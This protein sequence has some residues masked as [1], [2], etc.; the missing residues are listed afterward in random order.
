M[1]YFVGKVETP[2]HLG[3]HSGITHTDRGAL[4]W[5]KERL[6]ISSVLDVG[7][8]V[9]GQVLAARELGLRAFGIDGDPAVWNSDIMILHDFTTGKLEGANYELIWCVE[10]LEHVEVQYVSNVIDTFHF[11]GEPPHAKYAIVTAA[12]KGKKGFHHVNC[13]DW[14]WWKSTF[15]AHGWIED[16]GLTQEL[17]YCSTM[18]EEGQARGKNPRDF[19]RQRGHLLKWVGLPEE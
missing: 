3:G 4:K 13:Q 15:A 10:M 14:E 2:P 1:A 5:A 6:N 18:L 16:E 7:C 9:G 17:R 12:P 19:I 8:G 11:G